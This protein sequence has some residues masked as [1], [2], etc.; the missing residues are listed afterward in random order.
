MGNKT[1]AQGIPKLG[2][3]LASIIGVIINLGD[4]AV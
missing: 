3:T 1:N 4:D 2:N